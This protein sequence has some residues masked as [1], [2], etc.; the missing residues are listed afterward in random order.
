M[1]KIYTT[2]FFTAAAI[3]ATA[4]NG[5]QAS[6]SN[7]VELDNCKNCLPQITAVLDTICNFE[8][9]DTLAIYYVGSAPFDSGWAIGHNA[10]QD[11][12]WA[13]RFE[14]AGVTSVIG[15]VYSLYEKSGTATSGGSAT[16]HV[17]PTTGAGGKPGASLGSVTIPFTSMTN[18]GTGG[19]HLFAFTS[20]IAVAD[21][22][23][24]GFDLGTYTLSGPDTIGVVTSR[25]GNRSTTNPDQNC[26]MWSDNSWYFELTENFMLQVTY[27][28]CA[29]V[30][31]Q[32]G[33]ENYVSKGD[34]NLYAAYP[35]P[36]T[37]EITLNYSLKNAG[38][39]TI[40]IFD[41]QG[42]SML[43]TEKANQSS[44]MHNERIDI[45]SLAEGNYFYKVA[46]E[47]GTVYSRFSVV[48]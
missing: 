30:D 16:A 3:V 41:A 31:I 44:G 47:N 42:K 32:I 35:N 8:M 12:A 21:S 29:I 24:M 18:L 7:S 48:K 23:F 25:Q 22:F 38:N 20:P 39:I 34:L 9:D 40:E 5:R 46:S 19:G 36:A 6:L 17:Y 11:K 45:S 15:G 26:A 27:G 14:A 2:I 1:K 28:L 43:K 4:Q 10:Y 13:E 33:I 37:K